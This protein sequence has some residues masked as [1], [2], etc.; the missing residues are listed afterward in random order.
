MCEKI[1]KILLHG[2][3][4]NSGISHRSLRLMPVALRKRIFCGNTVVI[5]LQWNTSQCSQY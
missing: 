2:K 4:V 5:V 3:G 1:S